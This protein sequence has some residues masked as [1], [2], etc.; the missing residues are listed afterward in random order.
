MTMP[1][2]SELLARALRLPPEEKLALATE[3]L[4]SVEGPED[5]AWD[6]AWAD[7]LD[8]RLKEVETGAVKPIP[9]AEAKVRLMERLRS[10]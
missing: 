7:E 8:R 9:W 1:E 10:R 5:P 3:L 6:A 4:N 2:T